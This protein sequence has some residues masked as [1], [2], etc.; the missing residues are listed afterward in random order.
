M[1][2]P[3]YHE[4]V[5]V[6][7]VI[8]HWVTDPAGRYLDGTVGGGG[9]AAALLNAYPEAS[10][11]GLDRD[12]DALEAAAARLEAF[13]SRVTLVQADFAEMETVLGD[14]GGT[15]VVGILLDL[16]VSSHQLDDPARGFAH[17]TPGPLRLMLDRDAEQTAAEFLGEA[18]EE[19]L[20]RVFR[21]LGELPRSGRAA[22][23]I[24]RARAKDPI[25]TTER[26]V[27]V[28]RGA[29]VDSPRRLSQAFQAVR[30]WVNHELESLERGLAAAVRVLPAGGVLAVISFESLM[31]RMVK[32]TFRPPR[33]ERPI[34]GVP[35]AP[36]VWEV[37]TKK[38]IRPG[39][40]ELQRNPRSRSARLRA[41]RRM[42]H[43]VA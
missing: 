18:S 5:L 14:H 12:P 42:N 32:Q 29:G 13:A 4:P 9:H 24:V 2:T 30:L 40:E 8:E 3:S 43:A 31:D 25:D 36:P 15:P 41:A 7:E 23:A 1:N 39:T 6:E 17:G 35:D 16:G 10:L 38:A 28:L 37:L 21:D 19:T 22:R 20:K 33:T 27:D 11:L 26:L 34:A